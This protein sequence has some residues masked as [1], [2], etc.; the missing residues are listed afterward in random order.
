MKWGLAAAISILLSGCASPPPILERWAD[1][2]IA[3]SGLTRED[4]KT[5]EAL[6]FHQYGQVG[7]AEVS[8]RTD[9][10][11][12]VRWRVRGPWLEIDADNDGT[13]KMRLRAVTWTK[14]RVVAASPTGKRS[15][16][17][18]DHAVVAIVPIPQR[19]GI[20]LP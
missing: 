13:Y 18:V 16:W 7:L 11:P 6:S 4:S 3:T 9:D 8:P 20:W 1:L 17:R 15:V 12:A 2:E 14:D 5:N 19:P 10:A